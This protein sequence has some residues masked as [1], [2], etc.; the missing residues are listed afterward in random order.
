M[1]ERSDFESFWKPTFFVLAG[2]LVLVVI[3]IMRL[4]IRVSSTQDTNL[5]LEKAFI[6]S[7]IDW[8]RIHQALFQK[9][10][11]FFGNHTAGKLI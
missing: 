3:Q 8:L 5:L 4:K 11:A 6:S 9:L 2:F 1:R 7:A 10:I